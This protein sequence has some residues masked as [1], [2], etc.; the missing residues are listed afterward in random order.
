[1]KLTERALKIIQD[2][3]AKKVRIEE[4]DDRDRL[5][6]ENSDDTYDWGLDDGEIYMARAILS[7]LKEGE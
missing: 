2:T 1:M 3:A 6:D 7:N 4:I 5:F